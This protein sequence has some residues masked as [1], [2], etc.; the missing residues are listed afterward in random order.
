[1]PCHDPFKWSP[2]HRQFSPQNKRRWVTAAAGETQTLELNRFCNWLARIKNRT[3]SEQVIEVKNSCQLAQFGGLNS[4][5]NRRD[6][7]W[8]SRVT[9]TNSRVL[10]STSTA[11]LMLLFRIHGVTWECVPGQEEWY[12][13]VLLLLFH[14]HVKWRTV[15]MTTE[16]D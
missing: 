11:H 10:F 14:H 3:S 6:E 4:E 7:E 2:I 9:K 1:M 13:T 16:C 5:G 8:V 12:Q 15:A